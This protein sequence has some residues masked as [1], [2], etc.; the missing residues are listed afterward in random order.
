MTISKTK[1]KN[2]I[3]NQSQEIAALRRRMSTI[4]K[5]SRAPPSRPSSSIQTG[6][7]APISK[8]PTWSGVSRPIRIHQEERVASVTGIASGGFNATKYVINPADPTTFPWLSSIAALF[9]KYKFH[10]LEFRYITSSPTSSGGNVSLAV[11]FD[12]LDSA[13]ANGVA[14]S[15]LAKFNTFATWAN[16]TLVVPVN[17]RGNNAWLYTLDGN[18]SSNDPKTYNLGNLFVSTES[19]TS[20]TPIGYIVVEYDVELLDKNPN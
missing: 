6:N 3:N 14:M 2:K 20:T 7:L 18:A 1:L 19:V 9:D 17:R 12:T 11:D 8:V 5:R 16:E 10:K 13:P 4:R 15:N